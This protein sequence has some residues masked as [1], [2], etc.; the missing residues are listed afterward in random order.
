MHQLKLKIIFR[1][2]IGICKLVL[3]LV[4]FF[5]Y[6]RVSLLIDTFIKKNLFDFLT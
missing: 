6:G 3:C 2:N 1:M 4:R 5:L